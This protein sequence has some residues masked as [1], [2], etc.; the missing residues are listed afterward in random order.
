MWMPTAGNDGVFKG[1]PSEEIADARG[2][3]YHYSAVRWQTAGAEACVL[4]Y[5]CAVKPIQ[6]AINSIAEMAEWGKGTRPFEAVKHSES[7]SASQ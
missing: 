3:R 7:A 1:K 4:V 5:N 6:D 2:L